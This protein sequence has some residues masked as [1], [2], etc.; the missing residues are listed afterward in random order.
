MTTN[1]RR[2]LGD[3]MVPGFILPLYQ[4]P[5]MVSS[6]GLLC[7]SRRIKIIQLIY[8]TAIWIGN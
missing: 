4:L 5:G 8:F 1:L 7:F 6:I 2:L 3:I